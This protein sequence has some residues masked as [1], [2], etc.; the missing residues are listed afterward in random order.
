MQIGRKFNAITFVSHFLSLGNVI[1]IIKLNGQAISSLQFVK[2]E[3]NYFSI[4]IDKLY[5]LIRFWDTY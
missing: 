4:Q 1:N 3:Q 5:Q 2:L